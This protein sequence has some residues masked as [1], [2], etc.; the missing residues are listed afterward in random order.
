MIE[1][2]FMNKSKNAFTMIE[3]VFVIVILGILASIAI[4]HFAGT[5]LD[6]QI[7]KSRAEVASI[8][9]AIVTERQSRLIRGLSGFI[10]NG[11]GTYVVNGTTYDQMDRNGLFGGALTYPIANTAATDGKWSAVAGSGTYQLRL[12]GANNTFDY[13]AST[14]RFQ[15]I[16]GTYCSKLTN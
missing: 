7:A 13:N 9:S 8:R 3:L 11:T 4:P 16:S 12:K 15:C 5:R 14:G 10:P 2:I 6:A 1:G